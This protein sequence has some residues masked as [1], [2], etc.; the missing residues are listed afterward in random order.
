ME[1]MSLEKGVIISDSINCVG[2]QDYIEVKLQDEKV[3]II[4]A[5]CDGRLK[6]GLKLNDGI[7][8]MCTF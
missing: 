5:S 2:S 8:R 3:V 4:T 7:C 6:I 1:K